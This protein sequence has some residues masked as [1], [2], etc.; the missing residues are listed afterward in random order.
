MRGVHYLKVWTKKQQVVSLSTVESELSA[1]VKT[2]SD[3]PGIQILC[4]LSV[5]LDASG[6]MCLVNRRGLGQDEEAPNEHR[7][8]R[9]RVNQNKRVEVSIDGNMV[10]VSDRKTCCWIREVE[11]WHPR[12]Q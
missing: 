7:G 5:H 4:G 11:W 1:A 12:S 3:G 9:F 8:L 6:T 10:T 2:A